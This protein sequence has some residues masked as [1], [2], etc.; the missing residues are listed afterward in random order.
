MIKILIADDHALLRE[1]LA[2]LLSSQ[3]DFAIAASA[4]NGHE[5]LER[6]REKAID[7]LLLDLSMPGRH[8]VDLI[9][10]IK[11]EWP[12]LPILVVSMHKEEQYALIALRAGATGYLTKDGAF[13]ELVLAIR[14][15]LAGEIYMSAPIARALAAD[16]VHPSPRGGLTDL[17][18]REFN[19]LVMIAQGQSLVAIAATLH[20]S[21]K[22]VSTYTARL[23]KKLGLSDNND[24]A[25]FA[26]EHKLL[27]DRRTK[28]S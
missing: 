14:K 9:K 15:V 10:Q 23:F 26:V 22:T 24:L 13:E 20:L 6:L 17:S 2:Q 27:S 12:Q 4:S 21:P 1:G 28:R 3:P 18:D 25:R 5:T 11:A 19:V 16:L 7:I 8:G